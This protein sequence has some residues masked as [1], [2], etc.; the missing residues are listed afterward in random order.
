M[1]SSKLRKRHTN[2]VLLIS[3]VLWNKLY[4]KRNRVISNL[5]QIRW[6]F[7]KIAKTIPSLISSYAWTS[8]AASLSL[9]FLCDVRSQLCEQIKASTLWTGEIGVGEVV[10][11]WSWSVS[12]ICIVFEALTAEVDLF[13][14]STWDGNDAYWF[15]DCFLLRTLQQVLVKIVLHHPGYPE[16]ENAGIICN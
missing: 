12:L 11:C 2:M 3:A 15:C 8:S 13:R 1:P 6:H 10:D 14:F 5:T 9:N 4:K 7:S 16:I